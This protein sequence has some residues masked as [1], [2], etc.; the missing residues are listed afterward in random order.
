MKNFPTKNIKYTQLLLYLVTMF[1]LFPLSRY[2]KVIY[3]LFPL[4]FFLITIGAIRTLNV[5]SKL[6]KIF[7]LIAV[8]SLLTDLIGIYKQ[9]YLSELLETLSYILYGIFLVL[10]IIAIYR[11]VSKQTKVNQEVIR[12][13]I[14]IY[15]MI[16]LLYFIIYK[17]IYFMDTNAF[18]FP[19]SNPMDVNFNLFYF[20]FVTLTTVG[21]GD[22]TPLNKFV[23][24]LSNLEALCG[25]IFLATSIATLVSLYKKE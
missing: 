25:Q 7:Y 21:Y 15:I 6:I 9:I 17:L 10:S 3:F 16:G 14:C 23:M 5:S 12:A 19:E 1:L 13:G 4:S 2:F 18:R 11:K 24:M 20:S 22:I 8:L